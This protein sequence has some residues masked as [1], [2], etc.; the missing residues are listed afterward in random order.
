[1]PSKAYVEKLL[2]VG[3]IPQSQEEE[4]DQEIALQAFDFALREKRKALHEIF[5]A[6]RS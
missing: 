5:E 6:L 2:S 3:Y 1:M 4:W